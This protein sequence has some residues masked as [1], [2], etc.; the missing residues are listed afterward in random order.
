MALAL[1]QIGAFVEKNMINKGSM[2]PL[3]LF[4]ISSVGLSTLAL[5]QIFFTMLAVAQT[6]LVI[7][8]VTRIMKSVISIQPH[9]VCGQVGNSSTVFPIQRMGVEAW[10][11]NSLQCSDSSA[12]PMSFSYPAENV[13]HLV[14]ALDQNDRLNQCNAIISGYQSSLEHN[15]AVYE[16]VKLVKA[17]RVGTL[18]VCHPLLGRTSQAHQT[19]PEACCYIIDR[20]MSIADVLV[21]QPEELQKFTGISIDGREDAIYACQR[22]LEKGPKI[23]L[24]SHLL[25]SSDGNVSMM[26]ATPKNVY[27]VQ[28]PWIGF[29]KAPVGVDDLLTAV[30]TACLVNHMSPVVAL[31]HTNNALYGVLETTFNS[32]SDELQTVSAQY[33]FVEP[34]HDFAVQKLST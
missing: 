12:Q 18:Y 15:Q 30:Y 34:T 20:L 17:R 31:R 23:V 9:L 33:E 2:T 25:Y 16:T 32:G 11:I 19:Q 26:L 3:L 14:Q 22:A 4:A 1:T 10:A 24:V 6:R 7:T 5:I 28:R 8:K 29:A 21:C 13:S 27:L